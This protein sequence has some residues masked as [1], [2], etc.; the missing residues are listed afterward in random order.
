M[1]TP[2]SSRRGM[3]GTQKQRGGDGEDNIDY[4]NTDLEYWKGIMLKEFHLI[5]SQK[6]HIQAEEQSIKKKGGVRATN[7]RIKQLPNEK[8]KLVDMQTRYD[9]LYAKYE[10]VKQAAAVIAEPVVAAAAPVVA[11]AGQGQ[12]GGKSKKIRCK[13]GSRRNRVTHRCRKNR[14]TK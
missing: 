8:Q 12:M 11:A 14:L 6:R 4:T 13:K 5:T 3:E 2:K 1:L 7:E 9:T 10:Q